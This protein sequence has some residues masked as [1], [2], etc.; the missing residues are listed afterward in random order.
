MLILIFYFTF[1]S[2]INEYKLPLEAFRAY[3][4]KH[5]IGNYFKLFIF[6]TLISVYNPK[7]FKLFF[8][9]IYNHLKEIY[10]NSKKKK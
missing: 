3:S 7:R 2:L 4:A 6:C 5:I 10:N 9:F 8:L 1:S